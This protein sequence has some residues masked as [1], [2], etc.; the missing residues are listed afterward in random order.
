LDG[1]TITPTGAAILSAL[2]SHVGE[3]P[4]MIIEKIGYGAGEREFPDR[5]NLLRVLLGEKGP[6]W[7]HDEM[8]V[9]ETNIDDMNPEIYDYVLDR[10]FAAGARDVSLSPIQMKK[11]RPGTLLRIIGEPSTRDKLAE[12]V[13]KETSTIGIRYYPVSRM[14]LKRVPLRL[15]T[16]FGPVRV[17]MI[18]EP[19][20]DKRA[21]PEYDEMRKLAEAKRVPIKWLYDEVLRSF[22]EKGR[23]SR[24][25]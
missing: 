3:M 17:K 25:R 24:K 4:Q 20:G 18:E 9:L 12:I 8:L 21:V 22:K 1:E 5:P 6:A 13:F 23:K 2:A 10:L 7:G 14:I 11:N 19:G 16:R 15:K